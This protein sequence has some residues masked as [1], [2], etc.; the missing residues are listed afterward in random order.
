MVLVCRT[1]SARPLPDESPRGGD[2]PRPLCPGLPC[3]RGGPRATLVSCLHHPQDAARW[4]RWPHQAGPTSSMR[5]PSFS[6][7]WWDRG[8]CR[9]AETGLSAGPR[10]TVDP[11]GGFTVT[12]MSLSSQEELGLACPAF[13]ET[14][15][16]ASNTG[17]W[18]NVVKKSV[19]DSCTLKQSPRTVG[20]V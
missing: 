15:E 2:S 7:P 8:L 3:L 5:S 17:K 14:S 12:Q 10:H 11:Q 19:L 18:Q 1:S 6:A 20:F 13:R 9:Q 16:N 4:K